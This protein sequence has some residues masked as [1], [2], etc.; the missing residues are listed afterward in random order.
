M[1]FSEFI[2]YDKHGAITDLNTN[3]NKNQLS[4]WHIVLASLGWN[5]PAWVSASSIPLLYATVGHAGPLILLVT[6]L[7]STIIIALS[8]VY[9][10]RQAPSAAG[11]FTFTE[12]FV[13]HD[14]GVIVGTSYVICAMIILGMTTNVASTYIRALFPFI[15]GAYAEQ[16]VG[17]VF[18][19]ILFI[20][21]WRGVSLNAKLAAVFLGVEVAIVVGLGI[22]GIVDPH[23]QGITLA[24]CYSLKEA[25]GIHG[26]VAG[27]LIG[28]FIICG[29]DITI[30]FIEE[31]K[32]P[33]RSVQRSLMVV[34]CVVLVIYSIATIGWQ[35]AVPMDVL[36]QYESG[37]GGPIAAVAAEYLPASLQW[38]AIFVVITSTYAGFQVALMSGA[39]A[40]Y[41]MSEEGCL[42]PIFKSLNKHKTPWF[43]T[44]MIAAVGLIF[45]WLKP[46]SELG[47]YINII[48][49][50][51]IL[52]FSATLVAFIFAVFKLKKR[53][54]A[55]LASILPAVAICFMVYS[56]YASG[57]GAWLA[58]IAIVLIGVALIILGKIMNKKVAVQYNG[59]IS[60]TQKQKF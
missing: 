26:L 14:V 27:V 48:S 33:V 19:V 47:W 3:L 31:A 60:L 6:F 37:N 54:S 12:K 1:G 35:R 44:T 22:C 46:M 43:S 11:V 45:S 34:I 42:P 24:Q 36:V 25:G 39:R 8:L 59:P 51:L 29:Y 21:A 20:I 40:A 53:S 28:I 23:I 5:A 49:I 9:L 32:T 50:G 13:H 52:S 58:G 7:C 16:I 15:Q 56:G 38:I 41:R 17:T 18:L 57:S 2:G 30:N 55:I 10:V 4:T